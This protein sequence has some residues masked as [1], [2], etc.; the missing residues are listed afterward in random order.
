[1]HIGELARKAAVKHPDHPV[2]ERQGLLPTPRG[3]VPDTAVTQTS[4]LDRVTFIKRNQELGFTLIEIKQL[5]NLHQ[6]V[7][8]MAFPLRRKPS[9]LRGSSKSDAN[10]WTPLTR[11]CKRSTPCGDNSLH[12]CGNSNPP[13]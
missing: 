7:A 1:M 10:G 4:D 5:V 3:T 6:A 13:P 2:Y 8:A 11:K 9:E 12:S